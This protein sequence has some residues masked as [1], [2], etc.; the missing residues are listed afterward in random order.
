MVLKRLLIP[1]KVALRLN[2]LRGLRR[3][4]IDNLLL[5]VLLLLRHV[6]L[7]L[8]LVLGLHELTLSDILRLLE[9]LRK[10]GRVMLDLLLRL[11]LLGLLGLLG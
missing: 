8:L 1:L 9:V 7:L 11:R 4:D 10:V 2:L 5:R 6:C 3:W